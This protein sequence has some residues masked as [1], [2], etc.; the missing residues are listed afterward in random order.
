[1]SSQCLMSFSS[2][3]VSP[4]LKSGVTSHYRVPTSVC[5]FAVDGYKIFLI[6]KISKE[7]QN[8][9]IKLCFRKSR[10]KTSAKSSS[11]S[12][13]QYNDSQERSYFRVRIE[14]SE[15]RVQVMVRQ[16]NTLREHQRFGL[17]FIMVLCKKIILLKRQE[18]CVN[19]NTF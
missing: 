5:A 19:N 10:L 15:Q 9:K 7:F 14:G 17:G 12:V 11:F 16:I 2:L 6:S 8:Y 1:M 4:S 18:M 3:L 13:F